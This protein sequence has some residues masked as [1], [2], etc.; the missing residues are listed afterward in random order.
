MQYFIKRCYRRLCNRIFGKGM[1]NK[2]IGQFVQKQETTQTSA[3]TLVQAAQISQKTLGVVEPNPQEI[4]TLMALFNQGQYAQV[5]NLAE[6]MT[7]RFPQSGFVWKALAVALQK[8]GKNALSAMQKAAELL[9]HDVEAQHNLAVFLKNL[10]QL[11]AAAVSY[12][13]VLKLKPEL[14]DAQYN[15]GHILF[16][17]GQFP[18]AAV[19]YRQVVKKQA[20]FAEAH[21]SLANALLAMGQIEAAVTSYRLALKIKPDF[22]EAYYNLGNAFRDLGQFDKVVESYRRALQIR[23]DFVEVHRN[24]GNALRELGQFEQALVSYR[25]ALEIKPDFAEVYCNLG[26]AL[27]D[28]GRL[29]D[30]VASY[31]RALE[32][33]PDS[34]DVFSSLLFIENYQSSQ[35]TTLLL[36]AAQRF[37]VLAARQAQPYT[38]WHRTLNSPDSPGPDEFQYLRVGLVSGDLRNHPVGYFVE[39]MLA[40][41]AANPVSGLKF[42]IYHNH[43]GSDA[44]TKRVKAYCQEWHVVAK[45]S[46]QHLAQQIHQDK[47]D[48]LIDLSGHTDHNRLTM[49]AY[50]P[51]PVQLSWLGYFATT[52]VRAID[53]VLADPWVLTPEEEI[54]FTEK[55]WRLPET[56]LC[57]T[58]PDVTVGIGALPALCNGYMTFAC[59]NNLLKMNDDVV[60]LWAKIL[61]AIPTSRLFL[62]AKQL[63]EESVQQETM[64]R[65]ARHGINADRLILQGAESREKYLAAYHQVDIALDPF[66][67]PGGTTSVEGLWMGVPVLTLAG[68]R[69]LSRQGVGILA[70]AGLQ[71]WIASDADD[72]VARALRHASDVQALSELRSGLRQQVLSSPLFD[73]QRFAGHFETA[74]RGMWQRY[75]DAIASKTTSP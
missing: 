64:A 43:Y 66:P 19:N 39:G 53:Y 14:V 11:E 40:T 72:Y 29:D 37:G 8:Q 33:Q 3:K 2:Q 50:K 27:L 36:E 74:L 52:A 21:C 59:F 58:P 51:A 6:S 47:I 41:F 9:P 5:A 15:L 23:P 31:R 22:A 32:I 56:R 54:Y 75:V 4:N 16:E 55:I 1:T 73:A 17:L 35:S 57:F 12:R 24:L 68:E 70:N 18:N 48:I 38:C 10:G 69:F 26:N 65:F 46:D 62:K 49:F 7:T 30:A 34:I 67:F 63:N 20:N 13:R 61:L 25:R 44:L 28:L 71:D 42:I 45:L 60:A